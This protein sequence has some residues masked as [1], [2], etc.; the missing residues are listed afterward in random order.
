LRKVSQ[1]TTI[2]LAAGERCYTRYGFHKLLDTYAVDVIQ[3]DIC[4]TGGLFEAKKIAAMAEVYNVRVAPHNYGGTLATAAA[5]QLAACIPNFMVLEFFPYYATEPNYIEILENPLEPTVKD[6]RLP[7]PTS[8][9]LGVTLS[10]QPVEPF[11]RAESK[12]P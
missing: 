6:G 4:N 7:V 11:L 9:G 8:P 10:R 1:G 12:L 2:P 3:P 5:V